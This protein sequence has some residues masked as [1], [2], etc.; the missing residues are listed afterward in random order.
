MQQS[1]QQGRAGVT[2]YD[3]PQQQLL[4]RQA[5]ISQQQPFPQEFII[6]QTQHQQ[7]QLP[8][9]QQQLQPQLLRQQQHPQQQLQQQLLRQ[10]QDPQPL[11][12]P[13]LVYHTPVSTHLQPQQQQQQL[14]YQPQQQQQQLV[15]QPQQQQQ[16][17]YQPQQQQQLVYQPQQQQQL[18]YQPQ[19][20]QQLVYQPQQQQQLV[21]QPQQQQQLVYQPQQQ[22]QLHHQRLQQQ[23]EHQQQQQLQLQQQQQPW[24]QQQRQQQQPQQH[25]PQQQQ[26]QVD[27]PQQQQQQPQQQLSNDVVSEQLDLEEKEELPQLTEEQEGIVSKALAHSGSQSQVLSKAFNID[28]TR[29]HIGTLSGSRW[30][31]DEV[32][33]FY[34]KMIAARN[35][36]DEDLPSVHVMSSFF[37]SKLRSESNGSRDSIRRWTRTVDIFSKDLVAIPMNLGKHWCLA[38][39]DFRAKTLTCYDSLLRDNSQCLTSL[40]K[41]IQDESKAK[42]NTELDL[43]DWTFG[44]A[45]AIPKQTNQWDCG[46]FTCTYAAYLTRGKSLSF[47]QADIAYFRRRMMYEIL[48]QKLML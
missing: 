32:I 15:Y 16:L 5:L 41:Y 23:Q 13:Q 7:Q 26:Q 10:Q 31:N 20:Q 30:L 47:S 44:Q 48:S 14:V 33:N 29:A 36:A 22:Q 11:A 37:Y 24:Q 42:K 8:L 39:I 2:P 28:L 1:R 12:D 46:V 3:Q 18:V 34:F 17:V 19:Q 25:Q 4:P 35:D 21:Y 40:R 9:Q 27:Q 45:M 6:L 38:M 43:S